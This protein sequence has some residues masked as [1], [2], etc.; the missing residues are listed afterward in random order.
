M[1]QK[2]YISGTYAFGT[3]IGKVRLT[4]EDRAAALTNTKGNI[5]L[6]IIVLK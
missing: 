3:D 4:N 6:I 2:M 5:L 1:K